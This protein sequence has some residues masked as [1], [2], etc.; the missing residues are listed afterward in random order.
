MTALGQI[1]GF[2]YMVFENDLIQ[3]HGT[4]VFKKFVGR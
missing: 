2:Q 3:A 4:N 1:I